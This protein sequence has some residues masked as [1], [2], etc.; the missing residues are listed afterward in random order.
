MQ[1]PQREK[2]VQG[3]SSRWFVVVYIWCRKLKRKREMLPVCQQWFP[4]NCPPSMTKW[5]VART[6]IIPA[7]VLYRLQC[8]RRCSDR[9]DRRW[10]GR[11]ILSTAPEIRHGQDDWLLEYDVTIRVLFVS[12]DRSGCSRLTRAYVRV[13]Y[14]RY[15]ERFI[16]QTFTVVLFHLIC[17]NCRRLMKLAVWCF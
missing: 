5:T 1:D 14:W 13:L 9:C 16:S 2:F 6:K 10:W 11:I 17:L 12:A 4:E 15:S 7:E 8:N 3:L